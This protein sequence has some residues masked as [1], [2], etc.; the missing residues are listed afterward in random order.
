MTSMSIFQAAEKIHAS[1]IGDDVEFSSV[2]TDTRSIHDGDLFIALQGEHFDGHD[3]VGQACEKGAVAVMVSR[4]IS[5]GIAQIVVDDTRIGMGR[6]ASAWREQVNPRV[7]ALTGSNGKTT[8][9][10]ML[11]AIVSEKHDVL[12]TTGNLNNDI[13]VP[14]TLLRL[15]QEEVAI[16]EMGANHVGE[17]DYLSRMALPDIAILNNA[18]RAHIGEFGSEENIARA[19]AEI[20]N[21]LQ[22]GGIFIYNGDSK[23]S[24]LWQELAASVASVSFG[25]NEQ[26]DYRGML[27]GYRMRWTEQ[28]YQAEFDVHEQKTGN[29]YTVSLSLAGLH[30]AMNALAAVAAARELGLAAEHVQHALAGL[31]PVAGRLCPVRG[32]NGQLLIDD[33]YNANP[34]SVAAAIDVLVTAP[35][36]KIL[37]LGDLA[38]LGEAAPGMHAEL[39][40]L[41]ADRGVD[42][43]YTFGD[44]SKAASGSF[45]GPAKHFE[46]R[47]VLIET[48]RRETAHGDYLLV[49]GSRSSAMEKVVAGL[50]GEA[51]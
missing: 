11:S 47:D 38:E 18:G 49:K 16:V 24:A 19:K 25:V 28:G 44:L 27:D 46:S 37:V 40:A 29:D 9:K 30:N 43:L 4:A 17:I 36:R 45:S 3:Y 23:W 15:Q 5:E 33:T 22:K 32:A 34:D 50:G 1:V 41:A 14:L 26:A 35:G 39:G 42:L 2:S 20:L 12:A 7:I 10:E 13:G 31:K 6:L 21:G 51:C 48:L 8:L